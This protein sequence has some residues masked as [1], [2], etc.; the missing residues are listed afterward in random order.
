MD[1]KVLV[2]D[3]EPQICGLISESLS[4][5]GCRCEAA[6]SGAEGMA[7]AA[8]CDPEVVF[9]DVRLGDVDGLEML[10]QLLQARPDLIVIVM[11]GQG[12][13][14]VAVEAMKRG[15]FHYL[16]KPFSLKEVEALLEKAL[17]NRAL[18]REVEALRL[19]Q[20]RSAR[21]A[22]AAMVGESSA[23]QRVKEILA[24]VAQSPA[25][26]VL[27]HGETGTGKEVAAR[28]LHHLG[29]NRDRPFVAVNCA[30]IPK[31]LVESE[32]FGHERGAFT[33]AKNPRIGLLEEAADGTFFLDEIADLSLTLQ[34]KLLRVLQERVMRPVGGSKD[35]AVRARIVAASNRDLREA[36]SRGLF[37]EDL[38]YRLQIVPIYLPPLRERLEDLEALLTCFIRQFAQEFRHPPLAVSAENLERLRRYSWPGNVRE[39]RNCVERA[40]LLGLKEVE[41]GIGP[42]PAFP[43]AAEPAAARALPA[44]EP[45]N[46]WVLRLASPALEEVEREVIFKVLER[47]GGNKIQAAELLGI[48]RT[49]LYRKLA[50]YSLA[51]GQDKPGEAS[52]SQAPADGTMRASSTGP[53]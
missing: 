10:R 13:V 14:P 50:Q 36:V 16:T 52:A 48:N 39:L 5:A 33:D 8:Q 19:E 47:C 25:T 29:A 40:M 27:I 23:M 46:G 49:T 11:S 6:L 20:D 7:K 12:G 44:A 22:L 43:R 21:R 2:I 3:D 51:G 18:K 35:I 32:L 42:A 1:A 17:E 38:Y 45:E 31:T 34:A 30:S 15:A 41:P 37:R 28:I 9:L 4:A 24:K 26:T 53:G